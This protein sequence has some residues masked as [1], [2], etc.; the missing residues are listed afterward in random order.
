M[1]Y[2]PLKMKA[3]HSSETSEITHPTTQ[4]HIKKSRSPLNI[5]T[6][7]NCLHVRLIIEEAT[8]CKHSGTVPLLRL[9]VQFVYDMSDF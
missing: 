7:A 2:G 5:S 4:G 6:L 3:L 8:K 9:D 1:D